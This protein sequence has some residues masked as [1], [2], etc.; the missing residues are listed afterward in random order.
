MT[1][2]ATVVVPFNVQKKTCLLHKVKSSF[3]TESHISWSTVAKNVMHSIHLHF[4]NVISIKSVC[5]NVIMISMEVS[6][7]G[8]IEMLFVTG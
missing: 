3:S 6:G 2:L 4:S 7:A 1:Q 5:L 8:N